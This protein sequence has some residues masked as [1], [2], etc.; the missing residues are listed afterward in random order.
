VP[1]QPGAGGVALPGVIQREPCW[2]SRVPD[3][4]PV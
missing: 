4:A 3:L 2:A 1:P